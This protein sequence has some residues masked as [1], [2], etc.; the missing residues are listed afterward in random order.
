MEFASITSRGE[1]YN[2]FSFC[3][4]KVGNYDRN[5]WPRSTDLKK[6]LV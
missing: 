3:N 5:T 2:K 6:L 1:V 4:S